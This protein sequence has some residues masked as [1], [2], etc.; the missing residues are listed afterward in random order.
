[1]SQFMPIQPATHVPHVYPFEPRVM[2]PDM[3]WTQGSGVH[4]MLVVPLELELV[5]LVEELVEPPPLELELALV[6]VPPPIPELVLDA[7]PFP[8]EPL[9]DAPPVPLEPAFGMPLELL[10]EDALPPPAPVVPVLFPV[11]P[12]PQL[13]AKRPSATTESTGH[14]PGRFARMFAHSCA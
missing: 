4:D 7:P 1:M 9:V 13:V 3:L 5:L 10:E 8:L 6:A 2:Q 11:F 12:E 14:V